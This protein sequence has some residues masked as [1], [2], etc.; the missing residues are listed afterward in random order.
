MRNVLSLTAILLTFIFISCQKE[1]DWGL[2]GGGGGG[3]SSGDLLVKA[4]E[5]TTA[6]NDTNTLT[7][8]WDIN[9][10]L[11]VYKSI[12]KV[13]GIATNILH[14]ITRSSD[15]K[16]QKIVSLSS[17]SGL[18][19]SVVYYP[20]YLSGSSRLAYIRDT[21]YTFIGNFSDS[22]AITYN[23][24][25]QVASKESFIDFFGL[26]TPTGKEAY[27]YDANGNITLINVLA[28]NGSGGYDPSITVTYTFNSKK[29][30]ITL[31]EESFIV[32][33]A[34]NV[35]KNDATMVVNDATAGGGTSYTG[36]YSQQQYNSFNRP[37]SAKLSLTPQPP[38]YDVA[39]S[40]FY[41]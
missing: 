29:S 24:S 11:L 21:Q 14:T 23:A 8:Q 22:A 7:F 17:S 36:T 28:P 3:S 20:V 38:G 33:G 9:K 35:S 10:R 30:A 41:Q 5:I 16:I 34:A 27:T 37:T 13:N 26:L 12:G 18:S 19:D 40:Y 39:V 31:G 25:G 2:S 4:L 1:I 32:I 15:G 6:T